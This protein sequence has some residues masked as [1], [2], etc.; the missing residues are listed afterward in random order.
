MHCCPRGGRAA[1]GIPLVLAL[2]PAAHPELRSTSG[3]GTHRPHPGADR[4]GRRRTAPARAVAAELPAHRGPR[5]GAGRG[6]RRDAPDQ[7]WGSARVMPGP[8]TGVLLRRRPGHR[9]LRVRR[10]GAAGKAPG[11]CRSCRSGHHHRRPRPLRPADGVGLGDRRR[12]G[13]LL[14]RRSGQR[15]RCLGGRVG[16][17]KRRRE[18]RP[19]AVPAD[20]GD[21]R[22]RP[23]AAGGQPHG[24][25][26]RR[27]LLLPQ[28]RQRRADLAV[29]T[30]GQ[31][32]GGC[33]TSSRGRGA[34]HL[35]AQYVDDAGDRPRPDGLDGPAHRGGRRRPGRGV[36]RRGPRVL[37]ARQT[38]SGIAELAAA[39]ILAGPDASPGRE[40]SAGRDTGTGPVS[41]TADALAATR[42]SI[43]R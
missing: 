23:S 10:P 15:G 8:E 3:P 38:S 29:G 7:P 30:R 22:R 24:G 41:Q 20:G 17:A 11:A 25:C 40:S 34:A 28:G 33:T 37:L 26:R 32:G 13:R 4:G 21:C 43:R 27:L 6:Q 14:R 19:A 31:P 42:W 2:G 1:A 12:A 5:D 35:P 9:V 39:Q 16:G 18:D 36:R